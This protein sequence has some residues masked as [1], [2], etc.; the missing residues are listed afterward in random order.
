VA[1]TNKE[2][3]QLKEQGYVYYR[4]LAQWMKSEEIENHNKSIE[5]A[6]QI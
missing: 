5:T 3:Q 1:R 4:P 6:A 2:R